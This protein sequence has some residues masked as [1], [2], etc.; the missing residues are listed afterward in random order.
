LAEKR[1]FW[2]DVLEARM[3]TGNL[4]RPCRRRGNK[5]VA[6]ADTNNEQQVVG[7]EAPTDA[8]R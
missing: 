3:L 1:F 8:A 2:G 5:P 4:G 7:I 6:A